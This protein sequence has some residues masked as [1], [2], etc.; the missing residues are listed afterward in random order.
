MSGYTSL[1]RELFDKPIWLNS[2]PEQ[3]C[4][5]PVLISLANH[6]EKEWE[7]DGALINIERGQFI[8][9]LDK[10]AK[11]CGKGVSIQN[12][13]TALKRFEKLGFLTSKPTNKCRLITICNYSKYQDSK[14]KPNKQSNKQ[15]TSN[16]QAANKQL[17]TT[18]NVNNINNYK[19]IDIENLPD[20]ISRETACELI[21]YRIKIKKTFTQESFVRFVNK[22]IKAAE[23]DDV[24][25]TANEIITEVIDNGWQGF[26]ASYFQN[27][28]SG[29]VTKIKKDVKLNDYF[30]K[31]N[32]ERAKAEGCAI[33]AKSQRGECEFFPNGTIFL[34]GVQVR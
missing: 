21:D 27:K 1:H 25:L 3:K 12:V 9:S 23:L 6:T 17:T 14:P 33:T 13:R 11:K 7:F 22:A 18:N 26:N 2:T 4:L 32:L 30:V 5:I 28:N 15:L 16:Q 19:N 8:T 24:F 31:V 10:L 34:E 29:N 20:E